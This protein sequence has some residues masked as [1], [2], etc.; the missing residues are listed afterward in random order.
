MTLYGIATNHPSNSPM[1]VYM[2]SCSS[3]V[4]V[5]MGRSLYYTPGSITFVTSTVTQFPVTAV[6]LGVAGGGVS[7]IFLLVTSMAIIS[8]VFRRESVMKSQVDVLMMQMKTLAEERTMGMCMC[9][10]VCVRVCLCVCAHVWMFECVH[11]FC[12]ICYL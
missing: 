12:V 8:V 5:A 10:C 7:L 6:A 1:C 2:C 9:V 11:M 3:Q 4:L